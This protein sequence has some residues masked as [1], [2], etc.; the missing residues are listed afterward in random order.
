[1]I[2]RV[3]AFC[4]LRASHSLTLPRL[5]P[6]SSFPVDAR[7]T[8]R[9][10]VARPGFPSV[11]AGGVRMATWWIIVVVTVI[12]MGGDVHLDGAFMPGRASVQT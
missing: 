11:N 3:S 1:M 10:P 4:V 5:Q 8:R 2:I 12:R 9:S 7:L 6:G